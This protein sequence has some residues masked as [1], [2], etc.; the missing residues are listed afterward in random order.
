[1]KEKILHLRSQGK[2]YREIQKE[3]G[4]S[5][6]LISYYVNPNGKTSMLNRQNKNRFRRRTTYKNMLGGRCQKCGYKKCMDALQFHHKDPSQKLFGIQDAVWG[7]VK[8]T[9]EEIIKEIEKCT[10][11]CANCHYEIHARN[12]F[13]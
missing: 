5:K 13:V 1:M 4:C 7:Q 9:E 10:L 2:T 11:L 8:A 3:L 12:Y 6:S